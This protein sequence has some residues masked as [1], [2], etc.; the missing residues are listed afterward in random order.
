MNSQM[1]TGIKINVNKSYDEQKSDFLDAGQFD[2]N[3]VVVIYFRHDKRHWGVLFALC[4]CYGGGF[5]WGVKRG[6]GQLFL[7][8]H[9]LLLDGVIW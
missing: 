5:W 9:I 6:R 1:N 3:R 4:D 2:P 7:F 8:G